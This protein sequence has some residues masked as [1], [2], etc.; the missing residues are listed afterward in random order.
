M[1]FLDEFRALSSEEKHALA[2]KVLEGTD[3]SGLSQ[4][5]A[6]FATSFIE[7]AEVLVA[8]S[9]SP[10]YRLA[11]D[12]MEALDDPWIRR[13]IQEVNAKLAREKRSRPELLKAIIDVRGGH[14]DPAGHPYSIA[15]KILDRVN[16][17][18]KKDGH[19]LASKDAIARRIPHT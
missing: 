7:V 9:K 3:L 4:A 19:K 12:L 6:R 17:R 13:L 11:Q 16:G 18:L 5:A 15:G 8:A 10:R 1:K 2:A 14:N